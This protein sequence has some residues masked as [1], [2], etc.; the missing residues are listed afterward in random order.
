MTIDISKLKEDMKNDSL[1]AFYTGGF[2]GALMEASDV[3][4]TP[5]EELIHMAQKKGIDLRKYEV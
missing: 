2:G 5:P 4:H 1:G 3:E